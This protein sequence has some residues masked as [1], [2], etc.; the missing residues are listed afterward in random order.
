[1]KKKKRHANV[2]KAVDGRN[3]R[4]VARAVERS[5]K[6][7]NLCEHGPEVRHYNSLAEVE[8]DAASER[9]AAV[10]DICGREKIIAAVVTK[11]SE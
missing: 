3:P 5:I 1:M 10:C 7:H 11:H 2:E 8:A 4:R 9:P 6:K